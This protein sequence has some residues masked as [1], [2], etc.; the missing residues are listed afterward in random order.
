[1]RFIK[2][3]LF[4]TFINSECKISGTNADIKKG[5]LD[6]TA[7]ER[8]TNTTIIFDEVIEELVLVLL[9]LWQICE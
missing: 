7:E 6:N 3:H 1:M 2:S 5:V 8:V 9:G 4:A